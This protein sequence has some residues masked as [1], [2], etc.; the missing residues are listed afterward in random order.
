MIRI[1]NYT[2]QKK[3]DNYIVR[4]NEPI[5]C[6]CGGEVLKRGSKGYYN[7]TLDDTL[8]SGDYNAYLFV[9][10]FKE[11]GKALNSAKVEFNMKVVE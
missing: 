6:N 7:I 9:E 4:A 3:K 2:I 11:E 1:T 10:C 8:E 5:R